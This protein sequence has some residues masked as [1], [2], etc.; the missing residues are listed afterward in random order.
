[1]SKFRNTKHLLVAAGTGLLL[2]SL[3]A[4]GSNR[5]DSGSSGGGQGASNVAGDPITIGTTDS[6]TALDPAGSYDQGSSTLEYNLYQTLL[7][8]PAG[9]NTPQG[10][11]AESCNYDDPQ[12]LT[13]KMKPGLKFSNGDPL[14]SSDVKFSLERAINIADPN[15]AAIYLLGSIGKPNKDGVLQVVPGAIETP[16]DSTVIFHLNKPDTTFQFVLTYPG[17]GAIVDEDVFPANKELDDDKVIGSGPYKLSQYKPGQQAVF[18]IN[19]E[20]SG[21]NKGTAPQVFVSYYTST[22]DL[23]LAVEDGDVDVAWRSLSPTDLADLK[24]DHNVKV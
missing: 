10:D 7:T 12:T 3:A 4:C 2:V 1:M 22:S 13:C 19:D 17:A 9:Q 6:V 20:Y 21:D 5:D 18:E 8:I 15:G 11:A 24:K 23:K 14:T 16:D